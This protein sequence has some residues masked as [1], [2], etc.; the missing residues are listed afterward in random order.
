MCFPTNHPVVA[1]KDTNISIN[2]LKVLNVFSAYQSFSVMNFEILLYIFII[3]A[4]FPI[5]HN[6]K[7]IYVLLGSLANL[8]IYCQHLDSV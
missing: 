6:E 8:L 3:I 2:R 7:I 1:T 4:V 5:S